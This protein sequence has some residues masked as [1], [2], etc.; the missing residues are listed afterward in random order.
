MSRKFRPALAIF[1]LRLWCAGTS[2]KRTNWGFK[3]MRYQEYL[4]EA[5]RLEHEIAKCLSRETKAANGTGPWFVKLF[6]GLRD[7]TIKVANRKRGVLAHQRAV[8]E[9][10]VFGDPSILF[11]TNIAACLR[12]TVPNSPEAV[13]QLK[14]M[15]DAKI[16]FQ[17]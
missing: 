16:D 4:K 11:N 2:A 6:P 12:H 1:L 14:A 17:R 9:Q 3:G 15:A 5:T 8:L 7:T 13:M 10:E